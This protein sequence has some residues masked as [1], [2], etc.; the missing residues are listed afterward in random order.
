MSVYTRVTPEQASAWLERYPL[1]TL[2]RLR[3]IAEGIENTNYEVETECGRFVLTLFERLPAAEL[4]FYLD[5]MAHLARAGAPCPAPAADLEGHTLGELNGKPAALVAFLPGAPVLQPSAEHCAR[6]GR[7]L[8]ELHLAAASFERSQDNPRGPRW[9]R[10]TA[11]ELMDRLPPE[12][13]ALLQEELRFQSLFRFPDLPRGVIHADLFRDNVLWQEGSVS[14]VIDFY[15]ACTDVLLYDVAVAAN[16]WCVLPDGG[17]D[18]ER[19]RALLS[20]YHAGRP[21][22]AIERGAWPVL[23]RAGAL[24]FWLSRLL[25]Y[26]A[27]RRGELT[28]TKNPDQFRDILRLRVR[29]HGELPR[30]WV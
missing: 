30:V 21:L 26:H 22:V 1:G 24:R 17:L 2:R 9:W 29:A 4:P 19:T 10:A 23:L 25:D 15:F 27:P 7:M 18:P 28:Y 8:A 11:Q 14:G 13:A 12:D 5:L 20:G 16:D 3:P 6:V